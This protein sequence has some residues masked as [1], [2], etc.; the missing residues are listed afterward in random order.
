MS[1]KKLFQLV[2]IGTMLFGA[3]AAS[4]QFQGVCDSKMNI[5]SIKYLGK[6]SGDDQFEVK[7]T[8]EASSEC[9]KFGAAEAKMPPAQQDSL[10]TPAPAGYAVHVRA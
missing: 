8:A 3:R 4:A 5:T 2:L 7:W 1:F 10:S 9:V 6:S